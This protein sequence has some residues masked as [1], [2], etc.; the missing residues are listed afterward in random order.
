MKSGYTYYSQCYKSI[1]NKT[2]VNRSKER[3][4]FS[5][6]TLNPTAG[7]S[8]TSDEKLIWISSHTNKKRIRLSTSIFNKEA[9]IIFQSSQGTLQ[10]VTFESTGEK[11]LDVAKTL[12]GPSFFLRLSAITNASNSIAKDAQYH[13]KCYVDKKAKFDS[14]NNPE[15]VDIERVL[16]DIEI[17]KT[18]ETAFIDSR[19]SILDM[20]LLNNY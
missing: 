14:I 16:A 8:S 9:C 5:I 2:A 15:I 3:F 6:N 13:L 7:I 19:D 11:K 18:V 4:W 12:V 10:K 20:N 1:V 17:V